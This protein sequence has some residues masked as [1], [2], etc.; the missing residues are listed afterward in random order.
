M[1][2]AKKNIQSI[3]CFSE[4]YKHIIESYSIKRDL[5]HEVYLLLIGGLSRSG[6]TT[7]ANLVSE[8]LNQ[9][10]IQNV[11]VPLDSWLICFDK[12]KQDSSV[13][14]RYDTEA[15]DRSLK[16]LLKGHNVFPP[17]YNHITRKRT[18]E[19]GSTGLCIKKGILIVEG[20]ISLAV[21]ELV[22]KS[23]LA[24]F[25]DIENGLRL[26]RLTEFY[27]KYKGFSLNETHQIIHERE[28]EEIPFINETKWYA[29]IIFTP[30]DDSQ[31][32][33]IK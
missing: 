2:T 12:R 1:M 8:Q 13:I 9:E 11:I 19:V 29:D 22:D 5:C 17:I 23:D 24:V 20:V 26:R 21:G 6:K 33:G 15:I 14:E 7:L 16:L 25:I 4:L 31:C 10:N 27:H 3:Y 28:K 32:E 30:K 18:N